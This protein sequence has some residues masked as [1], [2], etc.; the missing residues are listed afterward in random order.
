M[1]RAAI[2]LGKPDSAKFR[3]N[4]MS[5]S[6]ANSLTVS[7]P[8][9]DIT[10]TI[11]QLL[12]AKNLA[13]RIGVTEGCLAKW[14]VYGRGPKHLAVGRR[15]MYDPADVAAWLDARRIGSTSQQVAA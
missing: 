7:K 12:T 8:E 13:A 1:A 11:E 5:G 14:R 15:I 4:A 9:R 3:L 6:S 10:M 2:H